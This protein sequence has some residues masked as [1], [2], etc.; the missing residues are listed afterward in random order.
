M[1]LVVAPL[2]ALVEHFFH[3]QASNEDRRRGS[4]ETALLG[5][6]QGQTNTRRDEA[7]DDVRVEMDHQHMRS[8]GYRGGFLLAAVGYIQVG[9]FFVAELSPGIKGPLIKIGVAFFVLNPLMQL[10]WIQSTLLI[11]RM[12]HGSLVKKTCLGAVLSA[13]MCISAN[14]F[15]QV[16]TES[17]SDMTNSVFSY[18]VPSATFTG[19]YLS[20]AAMLGH[21]RIFAG[22]SGFFNAFF[23]IL[24]PLGMTS[25][26]ALVGTQE[27]GSRGPSVFAWSLCACVLTELAFYGLELFMDRMKMAPMHAACLR[28]TVLLCILAALVAVRLTTSVAPGTMLLTCAIMASAALWSLVGAISSF[29]KRR[30]MLARQ[31]DH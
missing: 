17:E 18:L 21:N 10:F 24:Y 4:S 6:D 12:N 15:L 22:E 9:I 20:S 28:C 26:C 19:G 27:T 23:C 11:S 1:L 2:A 30:R 25:V 16:S 13:F 3:C 29:V 7:Q 8:A 14:E 31:M 5:Q